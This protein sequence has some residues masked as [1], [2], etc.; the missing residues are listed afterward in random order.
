MVN[1]DLSKTLT[2]HYP[3]RIHRDR[4][5]NLKENSELLTQLKARQTAASGF[6]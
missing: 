6:N 2:F 1:A 4:S 5:Y 3:H